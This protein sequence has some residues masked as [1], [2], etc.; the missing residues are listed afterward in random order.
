MKMMF[1]ALYAISKELVEYLAKPGRPK[2]FEMKELLCLFTTDVIGNVAFGLEMN[3]F[4][5]P[6]NMFRKMGKEVFINSPLKTMQLMFIMAF[7]EVAR[8]LKMRV[9]KQNVSDFFLSSIKE[10][11]DYREQNNVVRPDFLNLMIQIKNKGKINDDNGNSIGTISF[12]EMAAQSY[13]F[14]LA[15]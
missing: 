10:T 6:D 5:D 8:K 12:D 1:T 2:E 11:V 14:F 15:G 9:T 7:Q 4:K 13:V 3:C